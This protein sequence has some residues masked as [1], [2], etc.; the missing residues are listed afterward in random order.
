ME[1]V[2]LPCPDYVWAVSIGHSSVLRFDLG[3]C[4]LGVAGEDGYDKGRRKQ[5]FKEPFTLF[6]C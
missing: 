5:F 1:D 3:G 6:L 4:S 2:G